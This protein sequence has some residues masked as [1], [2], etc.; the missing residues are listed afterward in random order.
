MCHFTASID[1]NSIC[2]ALIG[3]L[4]AG[5]F[6]LIAVWQS[7]KKDLEKRLNEEKEVLKSF[8]LSIRD[9]VDTI[10]TRYMEGMGER[11]ENLPE[12]TAFLLYYPASQNYFVTYD[13]NSSLIGR[14]KDDKLRKLIIVTYTKAKGLLDSYKMNNEM[15]QKY[16]NFI[17]L[18][19]QTNNAI[20]KAWA[21][22]ALGGL[23]IYAD[24][25]KRQH[26]EIKS[27]V[28]ELLKKLS[29]YKECG[30]IP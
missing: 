5:L 23:I 7:A 9:E 10:W 17:L 8:L 21:D 25:I 18:F 16:E 30:D 22:A 12:K 20:F 3:G 29:N 13:E 11:V 19:Q 14:V 6:S 27:N 26:N 1:W 24:G 15:V 2:S 4:I 28:I